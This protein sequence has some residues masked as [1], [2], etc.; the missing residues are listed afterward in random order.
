MSLYASVCLLGCMLGPLVTCSPTTTG[1]LIGRF[2]SM[3]PEEVL[4]SREL[5]CTLLALTAL[6]RYSPVSL[7]RLVSKELH[8]PHL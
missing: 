1:T 8:G 5:P 2:N 4:N 3:P 6:D 7:R